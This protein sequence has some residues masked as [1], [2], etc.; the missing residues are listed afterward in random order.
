MA[1]STLA[2]QEIDLD[3]PRR[4][5]PVGATGTTLVGGN[6]VWNL[7][8]YNQNFQG[9]KAIQN[10][11]EVRRD[12]IV[13]AALAKP[14]GSLVSAIWGIEPGK[15]VKGKGGKMEPSALD[16]E[17]AEA[18]QEDIIDRHY[19]TNICPIQTFTDILDHAFLML[20]FGHSA[21]NLW[22][23][24][25]DSGRLVPEFSPRLPQSVR[26]FTIDPATRSLASSNRC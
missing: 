20:D 11:E 6:E 5:Q 14:K 1:D 7:Q 17:I 3:A 18:A 12:P 26:N 13:A 16:K 9:A 25:G 21:F 22:W 2:F 24:E 4:R 15:S 8:D 19:G 23:A 10:Y